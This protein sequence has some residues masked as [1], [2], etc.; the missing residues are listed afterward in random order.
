MRGISGKE[1]ERLIN[2]MSHLQ[3][4]LEKVDRKELAGKISSSRKDLDDIY[5]QYEDTLSR[6]STIVEK[7]Y[8]LFRESHENYIQAARIR[9][10]IDNSNRNKEKTAV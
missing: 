7:Y 4:Q 8:E 10:K 3:K 2:A 1:H 9:Q 5:L 6:V